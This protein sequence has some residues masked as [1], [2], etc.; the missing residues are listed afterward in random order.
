MRVRVTYAVTER[1]VRKCVELLLPFGKNLTFWL[2]T[3]DF[4]SSS[5]FSDLQ[6][7]VVDV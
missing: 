6:V 5:Q 4:V 7:Y 1:E 2:P 3:L